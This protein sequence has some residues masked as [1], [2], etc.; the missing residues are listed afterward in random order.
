[1]LRSV[2]SHRAHKHRT[3]KAGL[4]TAGA[5]LPSADRPGHRKAVRATRRSTASS[6]S[7]LVGG[8]AL[9]IAAIGAATAGHAITSPASQVTISATR[10]EGTYVAKLSA[11][12]VQG[13]S[14]AQISRSTSRPDLA[15]GNGLLTAAQE[16][17]AARKA[18]LASAGDDAESYA[19]ELEK[20]ERQA[21]RRAARKAEAAERAEAAE[22]AAADEGD[23]PESE[24]PQ[25]EEPES[26]PTTAPVSPEPA[27]P[28]G[29]WVVPL[30][31]YSVSS[32]FGEAGGYW[33]SGY[34][35]G[36]DLA[37]PYGTPV[38][39]AAA[40]TVVQ[41]G[42]DGAYGNQIRLQ[43]DNGDQIWY[44]HLSSIEV[45]VGQSVSAGTPVGRVGETGN[46]YGAHLHLEYRLASN[47]SAG[48]DPVPYFTSHGVT[49]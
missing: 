46:A 31:G 35:T 28:S 24:E 3:R 13:S 22:T 18:S 7:A 41:T 38:V 21:A 1:M 5:S 6:A 19:A 39:A 14:V 29:G 20:A 12:A 45:T 37:A 27:S 9:G 47:L 49:F 23:E 48:V 25:S 10:H 11:A 30:S 40:A 32:L 17:A 44:N 2:S 15:K 4:S 26:T 8:A 43:I 36:L 34:H 16:Q 33:S 42:Y